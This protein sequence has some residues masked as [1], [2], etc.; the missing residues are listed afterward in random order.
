MA[1][2]KEINRIKELL[3]SAKEDLKVVEDHIDQYGIL[4]NGVSDSTDTFEQGYVNALEQVLKILGV[5][6]NTTKP[7]IVKCY[8]KEETYTDRD[9][10]IKFYKECMAMS[11]GCEKRRYG[12]ILLD[13]LNGEDYCDDRDGD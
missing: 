1:S 9:K 3:D 5:K 4:D 8:G 7:I 13:L 10:A 12:N 2:V 11:D 6:A